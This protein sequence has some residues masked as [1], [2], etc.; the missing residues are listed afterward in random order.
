MQLFE[1]IIFSQAF[2]YMLL[3]FVILSQRFLFFSL[4][5]VLFQNTRHQKRLTFTYN[6][7]KARKYSIFSVN[8]ILWIRQVKDLRPR[9]QAQLKRTC[10]KWEH[11]AAYMG[12]LLTELD[13]KSVAEISFV[14]YFIFILFFVGKVQV[15][16]N[17]GC[18]VVMVVGMSSH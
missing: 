3:H 4:K 2:P 7:L 15:P 1:V 16:R 18:I 5:K 6:R 17:E 13:L 11:E 8:I 14:I 9:K 12:R 10:G